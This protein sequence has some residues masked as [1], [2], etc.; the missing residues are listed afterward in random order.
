M[1]KLSVKSGLGIACLLVSFHVF[2]YE[3]NGILERD[4]SIML[5]DNQDHLF[6]GYVEDE[7]DGTLDI[8][9]QD[10]RGVVYSGTATEIGNGTY[11]MNLSNDNGDVA[12]GILNER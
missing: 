7:G 5:K 8:S 2:A 4:D 9:V 11:T 3:L 10:D 6:N 1:W 12:T